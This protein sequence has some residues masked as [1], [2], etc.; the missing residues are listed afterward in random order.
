M[1]LAQYKQGYKNNDN[2]VVSKRKILS[3]KHTSFYLQFYSIKFQK[4]IFNVIRLRAW[5]SSK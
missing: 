3:L 2:K 4:H 5:N 1:Y